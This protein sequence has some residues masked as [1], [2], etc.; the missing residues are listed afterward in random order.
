ME[1]LRSLFGVAIDALTLRERAYLAARDADRPVR[2]GLRFVVA[3]GLLVGLAGLAGGLLSYWSTPDLPTLKETVWTGILELP[4][5]EQ[6]PREELG[7]AEANLRTVYEAIWSVIDV[8]AP[9]PAKALA[10]VLATPLQMVVGWLTA[11][12][13]AHAA[14]RLLGG[15]A[16]L[17]QTLG[18]AS[19]AT[20]PQMLGVVRVV[21]DVTTAGLG[22]WG[23]VCLYVAI[24]TTHELDTRRACWATALATIVPIA[25]LFLVAAVVA[26]AFGAIMAAGLVAS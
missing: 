26:A 13:L 4:W 1:S 11:G 19:L 21:P 12:A 17:S 7:H 5:R 6:V 18:A 10:G 16:A 25:L 8:V 15:R 23:L 24:K 9:T 3:I 2:R 14:A 22:V 20:A